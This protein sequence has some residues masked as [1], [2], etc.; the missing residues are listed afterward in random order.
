MVPRRLGWFT[1]RMS[2]PK[3]VPSD[4]TALSD[5]LSSLS[6]DELKALTQQVAGARLGWLGDIGPRNRAIDLPQP[7]DEPS[8]LTLTIELR[9]SKPRIWR[10]LSLSGDLTLDEVHTLF[11]AAMGWSDSHLHR[12]QPGTGRAYDEPYFITEFDQEE[13][14]EGTMEDDVRLDQVLRTPGDRLIYLYDF[15][16]GWEHR[17]KLESLAPLTPDNREPA[18][19]GGARSCPPED[20]GGIHAHHEVAAWLRAGAPADDV[21]GPFEDAD[22]ARDWLPIGY[23][24]DA[25]DPAETTAAM[26]AW[27]SGD[28][29]PWRGLPEPLA[30]L[31]QRLGG[32]GWAVATAWLAALEPR[33]AV[34][35]DEDDVRRAARPWLAVLEAV[36]TRTKLTDAGY[37]PPAV[38]ERFARATGVTD[39]WIGKANRE[40]LTWPVAAL[41]Q[42]AQHVGLLRK[43]KGTMTLTARARAVADRPRGLVASVL[44]RLPLGRGFE[45]DAGWCLLLGLAAGESGQALDT[46]VAQLLTDLGWRTPASS[47]VSASVASDGTRST[48]DALESMAGGHRSVDPAL[49][50]RLARAALLGV[51]GTS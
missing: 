37:L 31:V 40:D 47:G 13:G 32:E 3:P 12:F 44:E 48:L 15:G 7:P 11:Q 29:L 16:D 9:G 51:D 38:V 21:P 26:R 43:A 33:L 27:A 2:E 28:H 46:G 45:A 25:F 1:G 19:L 6:G 18:C 35:L 50:A 14:D 20:V 22:H 4:P 49:R 10:R 23:D 8:L 5:W 42:N 30:G 24:P 41:R 17:V 39:W 34:E 36:G